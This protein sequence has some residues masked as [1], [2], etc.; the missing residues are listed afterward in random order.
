MCCSAKFIRPNY[1]L[2]HLI[3][4]H[5]YTRSNARTATLNAESETQK[6]T[7]YYEDISSSDDIFVLLAENEEINQLDYENGINDFDTRDL[8][9]STSEV[10]VEP[11]VNVLDTVSGHVTDD[12]LSVDVIDCNVSGN[13]EE[14]AASSVVS[15]NVSDDENSVVTDDVISRRVGDEESAANTVSE[16]EDESD[17]VRDTDSDK[18]EDVIVISDVSDDE[19]YPVVTDFGKCLTVERRSLRTEVEVW[20]RIGLR[21]TTYSGSEPLFRSV[22]YEDDYYK[23]TTKQ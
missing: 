11:E 14:I 17:Y 8:D 23:Y 10:I 18:S 19:L 6:S 22:R 21:F 5:K 12:I 13:N 7:A 3:N 16:N 15:A 20:T 1:L 2:D 9:S 4:I